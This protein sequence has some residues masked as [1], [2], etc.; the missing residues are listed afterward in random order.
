[1]K[2][3]KIILV[4]VCLYSAKE[5][6]YA[7]KGIET[8]ENL[9]LVSEFYVELKAASIEKPAPAKSFSVELE[10]GRHYR[11]I[12]KAT[13][14]SEGNIVAE[15]YESG[16]LVA[17]NFFA[18]KKKLYPYFDII[19]LKTAKYDTY[20]SIVDG[21]SGE[22]SVKI[23]EVNQFLSDSIIGKKIHLHSLSYNQNAK[24]L[25]DSS[26]PQLNDAIEVLNSNPKFSIEFYTEIIEA[27]DY[28]T[29]KEYVNTI[30]SEVKKYFKQ[31]GISEKRIIVNP[32]VFKEVP[33][34]YDETQFSFYLKFK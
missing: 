32:A 13:D 16:E 2:I 12:P 23:Y 25:S 17:T 10:S 1:M 34:N 28:D 33:Y 6:G 24:K 21:L 18:E 11:M 14:N 20:I 19:C 22:G 7:Q 15:L 3:V 5:Q 26:L 30:S 9:R 31:K 29:R 4:F 27:S 8:K